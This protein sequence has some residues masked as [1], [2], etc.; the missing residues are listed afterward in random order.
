MEIHTGYLCIEMM[1]DGLLQFVASAGLAAVLAPH[2]IRYKVG[3]I[4]PRHEL[5]SPVCN[6]DIWDQIR[7]DR[8]D[9]LGRLDRSVASP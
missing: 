9:R 4:M 1:C 2:V 8:L 6:H 3:L 7:M 5:V